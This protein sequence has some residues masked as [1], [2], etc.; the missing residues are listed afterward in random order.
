MWLSFEIFA[1]EMEEELTI[2]V[3]FELFANE[4]KLD[5]WTCIDYLGNY[6]YLR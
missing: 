4:D 1:E 5:I 3:S 6:L 2:S